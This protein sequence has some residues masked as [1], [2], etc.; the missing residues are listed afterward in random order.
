MSRH[1][2]VL[3]QKF[4]TIIHLTLSCSPNSSLQ[5]S[6]ISP[7]FFLKVKCLLRFVVHISSASSDWQILKWL[8]GL[9]RLFSDTPVTFLPN[10][11]IN[12]SGRDCSF[13]DPWHR[14]FGV[15]VLK[16]CVHLHASQYRHTVLSFVFIKFISYHYPPQ[17]PARVTH[18]P[19]N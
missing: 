16:K 11:I 10:W 12:F 5:R 8:S 2:Q 9:H 7:V 15:V 1:C 14:L 13:P 4:F 6:L 17:E 18:F 3:S 19:L